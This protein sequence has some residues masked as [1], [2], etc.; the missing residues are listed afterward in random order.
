MLARCKHYKQLGE[1]F[2]TKN[3]HTRAQTHIHIV[4]SAELDLRLGAWFFSHVQVQTVAHVKRGNCNENLA[5]FSLCRHSG[6]IRLFSSMETLRHCL[7]VLTQA[8]EQLGAKLVTTAC[9]ALKA[10]LRFG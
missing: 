6:D 5:L 9:R 2:Q 3:C 8:V 7:A 1:L 4:M 10:L